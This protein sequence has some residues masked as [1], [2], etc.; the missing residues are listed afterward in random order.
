M[1][2]PTLTTSE[3]ARAPWNQPEPA[4]KDYDVTC[5]QVLSKTVQCK[6]YEDEENWGDVYHENDHYTPIQLIQLFKETLHQQLEGWEGLEELTPRNVASIKYLIEECKNWIE[7]EVE[8]IP[9]H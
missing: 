8:Y 7:D 3:E 1:N 4:P 9:E 6:V 2:T 5:C